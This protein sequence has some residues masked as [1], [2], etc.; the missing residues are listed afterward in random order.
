MQNNIAL[1]QDKIEYSFLEH[2]VHIA[3]EFELDD[4]QDSLTLFIKEQAFEFDSLLISKTYVAAIERQVI[5]FIS[6]TCTE[7]KFE[8][9]ISGHAESPVNGYSSKPA[10]K[11]TRFAVDRRYQG[12]G[13]GKVLLSQCIGIIL[14]DILPKIGC[15]FIV[16][17]ARPDRIDWYKGVGFELINTYDNLQREH[18]LMFIDLIELTSS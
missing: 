11:I 6:T 8:D 2:N 17:D 12:I 7:I 4:P 1:Q 9:S 13:V 10:I 14:E 18:P 5:G 3:H 15:R 16:L